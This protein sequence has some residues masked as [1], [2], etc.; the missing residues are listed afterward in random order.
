MTHIFC[1][2]FGHQFWMEGGRRMQAIATNPCRL[3][4]PEVGPEPTHGCAYWILRRSPSQVLHE[5]SASFLRRKLVS[6]RCLG[7]NNV[8]AA[9][10]R[11]VASPNMDMRHR[12]TEIFFRRLGDLTTSDKKLF[13]VR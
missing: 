12:P 2:W 13:E 10:P 8:D 1:L 5:H 4:I 3:T 7:R 6:A 9:L 11:Q